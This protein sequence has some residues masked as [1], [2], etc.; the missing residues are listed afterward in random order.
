MSWVGTTMNGM[1]TTRSPRKRSEAWRIRFRS[2]RSTN[3]PAN[4]PTNS[5]GTAVTISVSPTLRAEWVTWNT[6]IAAARSVR[7]E[8]IVETSWAVHSSAKRRFR[9]T[10]NI[11]GAA[12]AC[13][14][15]RPPSS[16]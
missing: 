6:K 8:P 7:D 10:A 11:D 1:V 9:N 16:G 13:A 14:I 12:V 15:R 5:V 3:T 4:S 2:N